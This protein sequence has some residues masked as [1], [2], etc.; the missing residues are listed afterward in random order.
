MALYWFFCIFAHR[1]KI[2]IDDKIPYIREKLWQLAD[3][4]VPLSGAAI[5]AADV[6]DADALIVR[7]RTHCDESLLKDSKVRFVA[8]ATIGFDH[9]DTDYMERAGIAWTSCPG[10]NAASVAQYVESSL[11]SPSEMRQSVSWDVD[12]SVLKS[13]LSQSGLGCVSLSATHLW[14]MQITFP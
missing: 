11:F 10:C 12:M 4:V 5:S 1:M 3:E 14:G 13:K 2:I 7:T 9:I 6:R 8:T